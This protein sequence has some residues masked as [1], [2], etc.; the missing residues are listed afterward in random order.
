VGSLGET[1]RSDGAKQHFADVFSVRV[2]TPAGR[3]TIPGGTPKGSRQDDEQTP[4]EVLDA[5]A[6]VIEG[7]PPRSCNP[8]GIL[9][10]SVDDRSGARHWRRC[11]EPGSSRETRGCKFAGMWDLSA[12]SAKRRRSYWH[13]YGTGARS[14]D[15]ETVGRADG[16]WPADR[17][18]NQ[19]SQ[20]GVT[21][22]QIEGAEPFG[23]YDTFRTITSPYPHRQARV[24]GARI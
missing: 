10:R 18:E 19:M 11:G 4:S 15:I 21:W 8:F 7:R 2:S 17:E 20:P 12:A 16:G 1:K 5:R 6:H 9:V 13:R 23:A 22:L 3:G 14:R 24:R